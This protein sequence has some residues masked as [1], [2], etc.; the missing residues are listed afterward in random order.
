MEEGWEG[1]K[2]RGVSSSLD[3]GQQRRTAPLMIGEVEEAG[4]APETHTQVLG[5]TQAARARGPGQRKWVCQARVSSSGPS[6][7]L[8]QWSRMLIHCDFQFRLAM[9][10]PHE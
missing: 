10:F 5:A 6:T 2:E 4:A 1:K 8:A 3:F 9:L 7:S